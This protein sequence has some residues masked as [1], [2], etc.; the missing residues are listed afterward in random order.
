M[1][2][3]MM[4]ASYFSPCYSSQE[5]ELHLLLVKVQAERNNSLVLGGKAA[6]ARTEPGTGAGAGMG[7]S[8][9]LSSI[10]PQGNTRSGS[11]LPF[12]VSGHADPDV[13]HTGK[14]VFA[15]SINSPCV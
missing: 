10:N 13:S 6:A 2:L 14:V 12:M 15:G 3:R 11:L 7:R 5:R 1:V 8:S 9:S 4:L